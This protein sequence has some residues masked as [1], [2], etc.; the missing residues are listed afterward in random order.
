MIT[1][2]NDFGQ[3]IENYDQPYADPIELLMMWLPPHIDEFRPL[4]SL[5]TIDEQG[6]P[7]LRH[8]LLSNYDTR[9]ITFHIDHD[10]RKAKQLKHSPKAAATLVWPDLGKQLIIQGNVEVTSQEDANAVFLKRSRYLQLLAWINKKEIAQKTK[11]ERRQ[12]WQAFAQEHAEGTL[13]AP[14]WWTSYRIKPI[15]IT[16]WRGQPDGPSQRH[17][18][19]LV[20]GQWQ[21]KVIPG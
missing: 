12:I 3:D 4:M 17:D 15:R 16:F 19:H 8:V 14:P 21:V 7:D 13:T 6:Y 1:A 11:D 2:R 18:Y 5:A 9:G 20:E 10:S